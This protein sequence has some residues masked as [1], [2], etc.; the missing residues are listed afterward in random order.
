VS[1]DQHDANGSGRPRN[2]LVAE[3]EPVVES[4]VRAAGFD[5]EALDVAQAGRRNVVKVVVDADEGVNLDEVAQASRLVATALDDNDHLI[6]GA[7]TL[8]VTSPGVDRPLTRPRHWRRARYRLVRVRPAEGPEF[9]GR[10]GPAGEDSVRLLVGGVLRDIRYTEVAK[11]V[12]EIEFKQPPVAELVMLGAEDEG[13][14][15][16]EESR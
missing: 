3:L 11:A 15:N 5:L 1:S 9:T 13:K 7:Y 14:N 2:P 8:E 16:G 4:A 6:G 10:V 12:V